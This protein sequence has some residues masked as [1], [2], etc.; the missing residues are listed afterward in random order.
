MRLYWKISSIAEY[1][2]IDLIYKRGDELSILVMDD[3]LANWEP[4]RWPLST[5]DYKL[6]G[7]RTKVVSSERN[8]E[9]EISTK[10][11]TYYDFV[12]TEICRNG[13]L[14]ILDENGIPYKIKENGLWSEE[15]STVTYKGHNKLQKILDKADDRLFLYNL[16]NIEE[17]ALRKENEEFKRRGSR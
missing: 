8:K 2:E 12:G 4:S 15:D 16:I 1:T 13:E 14:I 17:E 11:K 3:K 9:G 7:T 6:V 10:N 5:G